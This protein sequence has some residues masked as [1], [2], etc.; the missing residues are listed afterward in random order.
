[1]ISREWEDLPDNMKNDSVKKYYGLLHK[2]S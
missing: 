1:M 2:K